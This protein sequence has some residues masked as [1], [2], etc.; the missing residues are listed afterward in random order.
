MV[1][2]NGQGVEVSS[3]LLVTKSISLRGSFGASKEELM[4]VLKLISSAKL[5]PKLREIPFWD[6]PKGLED[7]KKNKVEGQDRN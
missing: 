2:L 7:I 6:V 5:V 4:E 3:L 1:G